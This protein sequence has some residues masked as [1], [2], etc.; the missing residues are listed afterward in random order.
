M[1]DFNALVNAFLDIINL[2]IPVI[3]AL[4]L[5]IVIWKITLAWIIS[6]DPKSIETGKHTLLVAVIALTVMASIWGIV[7]VLQSSIF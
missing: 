3:F 5:A 7:R 6:R 4:T 1:K 2:A